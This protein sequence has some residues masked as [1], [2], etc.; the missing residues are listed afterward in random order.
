MSP[1]KPRK[2][3]PRT[4]PETGPHV[5]DSLQEYFDE[6]RQF[7]RDVRDKDGIEAAQLEQSYLLSQLGTSQLWEDMFTQAHLREPESTQAID[8]ARLAYLVFKQPLHTLEEEQ[9]AELRSI[10]DGVLSALKEFHEFIKECREQSIQPRVN[11]R[12]ST[13]NEELEQYRELTLNSPEARSLV[14]E[15]RVMLDDLH[16]LGRR[17]SK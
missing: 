15:I 2:A 3:H 14:E 11:L 1:N 7:L 17:Y 9:L 16:R 8:E 6:E 13:S 12:L 4:R 5:W 10:H